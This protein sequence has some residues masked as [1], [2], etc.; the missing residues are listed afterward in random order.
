M[1]KKNNPT[2]QDY[3]DAGFV[4]LLCKGHHPKYNPTKN[5]KR[6][7]EPVFMGWNS[8]GY[9]PP[10]LKEIEAWEKAGGWT[11]WVIPKGMIVLDVE[12]PEAIARV[13]ALC[14]AKGAHPAVHITNNGVHFFF[15]TDRELSASSRVFTKCGIEVTY[16]VG[17]KN[18]LIL[19]PV[20]G[21]RWELWNF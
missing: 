15:H 10:T 4:P 11:G 13:E 16:R 6:A 7:K 2:Y 1:D 18:Y 5:Y 19:A 9:V 3:F 21:R 14:R 12:Y 17:G 8:P 20:N